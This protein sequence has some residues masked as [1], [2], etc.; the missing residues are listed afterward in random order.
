MTSFSETLQQ[1]DMTNKVLETY[2][3]TLKPDERAPGIYRISLLMP[4]SLYEFLRAK[5]DAE[6]LTVAQIV[7]LC[8]RDEMMR[9]RA[10]D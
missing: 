4:M 6:D 1:T 10:T 5:A 7:R 2:G 3:E 9:S 8:V